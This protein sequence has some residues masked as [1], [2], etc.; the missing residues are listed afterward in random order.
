MSLVRY[1]VVSLSVMDC[2]YPRD[3]PQP[4]RKKKDSLFSLLQSQCSVTRPGMVML[5]KQILIRSPLQRDLDAFVLLRLGY[6]HKQCHS[7]GIVECMNV[8]R[9]LTDI[10]AACRESGPQRLDP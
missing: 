7:T 5:S 6:E 9:G 2:L 4:V 3:P 1:V 8:Y 10:F